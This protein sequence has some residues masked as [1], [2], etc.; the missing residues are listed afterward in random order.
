VLPEARRSG[1]I[2]AGKAVAGRS[3][4][5]DLPHTSTVQGGRGEGAELGSQLA[6]AINELKAKLLQV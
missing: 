6:L 1:A 5:I 4:I 3:I 2:D